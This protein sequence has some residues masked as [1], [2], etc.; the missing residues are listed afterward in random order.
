MTS[1]AQLFQ[2]PKSSSNTLK[3]YQNQIKSIQS[4]QTLLSPTL[5]DTIQLPILKFN[6][7]NTKTKKLQN[8]TKSLEIKIKNLQTVK[9]ILNQNRIPDLQDLETFENAEST[10]YILKTSYKFIIIQKV[11]STIEEKLLEFFKRFLI[12]FKMKMKEFKS[13]S[14]GELVVHN[15]IYDCI[16]KFDYI[17]EFLKNVEYYLGSKNLKEIIEINDFEYKNSE[18]NEV[19]V[20]QIQTVYNQIIS[21][22]FKISRNLYNS[23]FEMHFEYLEEFLENKKS[24]SKVKNCIQLIIKSLFLIVKCETH[25]CH[26]VLFANVGDMFTDVV[27]LL[28]SFF[29]KIYKI[30]PCGLISGL[31]EILSEFLGS[32]FLKNENFTDFDEIE[33]RNIQNNEYLRNRI[34]KEILELLFNNL[35]EQKEKY[36][37]ER[38]NGNLKNQIK[39]IN[40]DLKFFSFKFSQ[41]ICKKFIEKLENKKNTKRTEIEFIKYKIDLVKEL[42][43]SDEFIDEYF[44]K[45]YELFDKKVFEFIFTGDLKNNLKKLKNIGEWNR[46]IKIVRENTDVDDELEN[47]LINK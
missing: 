17:F 38:I 2:K 21:Y 37:S 9:K 16:K 4:P 12:F 20:K 27:N 28:T 7:L 45:M 5:K 26:H 15:R 13:Q 33:T 29:R 44:N 11:K 25:F 39:K 6:N 8:Q 30:S 18:F 31:E 22:Y 23:E 42:N 35:K 46:I 1:I 41:Q 10:I 3:A 40:K 47:I 14:K 32:D 43:F 24:D 36:I 19:L 34:L